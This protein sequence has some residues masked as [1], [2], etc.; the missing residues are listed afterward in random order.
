MEKLPVYL[1]ALYEIVKTS[2]LEYLSSPEADLSKHA[3][4]YKVLRKIWEVEKTSYL[5]NNRFTLFDNVGEL[6]LQHKFVEV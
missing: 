1:D 2:E 6:I 4:Q 5:D 3:D